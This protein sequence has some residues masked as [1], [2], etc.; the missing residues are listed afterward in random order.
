MAVPSPLDEI[1]SIQV[2]LYGDGQMSIGGNIGDVRL[3]LQMLEHAS[4]AVRNQWA[5][6]TPTGGLVIPGHDVEVAHHPEFPV[7]P[8]GDRR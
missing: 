2:T 6:R 8:A 3:A 7:V 5:Q 1:A 4:D